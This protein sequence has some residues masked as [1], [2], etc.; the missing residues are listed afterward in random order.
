FGVF[1]QYYSVNQLKDQPLSTISWIG[2]LHLSLVLLI[3]RVSGPL[4]N[5][6]YLKPMLAFGGTLYVLSFH[7]INISR[8]VTS[9]AMLSQIIPIAMGILYSPSISMISHHFEK[10]R[11]VAFGI[12]APGASVGGTVLPIAMRKLLAKVGLQWAVRTRK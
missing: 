1:E 5:A 4:F 12:F 10:H 2:S 6:G 8:S 7:D 11:M 3:G 9:H